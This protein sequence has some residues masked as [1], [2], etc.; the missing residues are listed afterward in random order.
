MRVLITPPL[1][2]FINFVRDR[3]QIWLLKL[4]EFKPG[5]LYP[6]S[7]FYQTYPCKTV[8]YNIKALLISNNLLF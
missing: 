7:I 4:R 6:V 2:T 3:L 5:I 8:D 1:F